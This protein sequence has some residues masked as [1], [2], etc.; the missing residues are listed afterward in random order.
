MNR[1]CRFDLRTIDAVAARTFYSHPR[2]LGH[3]RAT[4]WPLHEQALARGARP[5]WLGQL[6]VE[7]VGKAA[8]A[9]YARGAV[10]LGPPRPGP[11]GG[12]VAVMRDPGGAIVAV[13]T[14][15]KSD[16]K[17]VDVVWHVLH[18]SDAARATANYCELFGWQL[19]GRI[20]LGDAGSFQ[21]F[22]WDKGDPRS[23]GAIADVKGRA[24]VHPHWL[25]FFA[26]DALDPAID[27]VRSEGGRALDPIT[28]PGGER[29]AICDDPQ[30][31]AFGLREL[32]TRSA[33][34]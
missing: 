27:A 8:T 23:A 2:I 19:T 32:P 5:H 7:D 13:G 4:I 16:V 22:A 1:F 34:A 3:D 21:Q 31:A 11:D 15:P 26:V 6:A 14:R 30:G 24:G 9:F 29:L 33:S 28:L 10:A 18:T 17:G 25:F 20:E 12:E